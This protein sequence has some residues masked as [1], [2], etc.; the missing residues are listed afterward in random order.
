MRK[1]IVPVE[2]S[3]SS[4]GLMTMASTRMPGTATRRGGIWP[5]ATWRRAWTITRPPN[6][7][8]ASAWYSTFIVAASSSRLTLPSSSTVDAWINATSIGSLG[9]T[10][11]SPPST[12]ASDTMS[13]VVRALSFPPPWRGS[14]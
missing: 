3:R 1:L 9:Y 7:F 11:C 12:V 2:S 10:M 13:S 6:R 8:A 5:A 14:M 4:D